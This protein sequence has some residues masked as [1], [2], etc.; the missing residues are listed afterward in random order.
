MRR[1][2]CAAVVF[3]L[4]ACTHPGVSAPPSPPV[5]QPTS[6]TQFECAVTLPDA[7]HR[8]GDPAG[9]GAQGFGNGEVWV[10]LWPHGVVRATP[11]NINRHGAIVV[12]F[13]WD[14]AVRGRLRITGRRLDAGAPPL[15]ALMSDYGPIGFQPSSLVFPTEGCWEITGRVAGSSLTFVTRV[16]LRV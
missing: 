2:S 11:D 9:L 3:A 8:P 12:K 14:R 15:R 7:S 6:A 5:D 13:P 16:T 10:G 1:L 4:V